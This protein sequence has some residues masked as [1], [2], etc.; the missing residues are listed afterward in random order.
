MRWI[1]GSWINGI[2]KGFQEKQDAKENIDVQTEG[3]TQLMQDSKA[4]VTTR[5]EARVEA[6]RHIVKEAERKAEAAE[7]KQKAEAADCEAEAARVA[8]LETEV[9]RL[10]AELT[11][12]AECNAQTAGSSE[13]EWAF[14]VPVKSKKRMARR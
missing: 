1:T 11:S 3:L 8:K 12:V 7:M 2:D 13:N 4:D 14:P 9:A 6:V 10:Q 5:Y